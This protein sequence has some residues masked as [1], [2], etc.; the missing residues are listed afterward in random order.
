M[1]PQD[2][3]HDQL[4]K[5]KFVVHILDERY[6]ME[7]MVTDHITEKAIREELNQHP[8]ALQMGYSCVSLR[9]AK[10]ADDTDHLE[11][12]RAGETVEATFR[13]LDYASHRQ[14]QLTRLQRGDKLSV[15]A[16]R[17][18]VAM[19]PRFYPQAVTNIDEEFDDPPPLPPGVVPLGAQPATPAETAESI[20]DAS[21][22]RTRTPDPADRFDEAEQLPP[23]VTPK[24]K[25]TDDRT[26]AILTPPPSKR[27]SPTKRVQGP[28]FASQVVNNGSPAFL[29]EI[30]DF[31][32]DERSSSPVLDLNIHHPPLSS[33]PVAA[34]VPSEAEKQRAKKEQFQLEQVARWIKLHNENYS[35]RMIVVTGDQLIDHLGTTI[36]LSRSFPTE[37]T[38]EAY[39][40]DCI[41]FRTST[42]NADLHPVHRL[43]STLTPSLAGW[44]T[45]SQDGTE[46]RVIDISGQAV[47]AAHVHGNVCKMVLFDPDKRVERSPN[48]RKRIDLPVRT[49]FDIS[50]NPSTVSW[51]EEGTPA[52]Y[53]QV[54][55]SFETFWYMPDLRL[56]NEPEETKK[57]RERMLDEAA[58]KMRTLKPNALFIADANASKD[59]TAMPVIQSLIERVTDNYGLVFGVDPALEEKYT[60]HLDTK[61]LRTICDGI[62]DMAFGGYKQHKKKVYM[63]AYYYS[64][65]DA[66]MFF[67]RGKPRDDRVEVTGLPPFPADRFWPEK[68]FMAMPYYGQRDKRVHGIHERWTSTRATSFIVQ[69]LK[70]ATMGN[71]SMEVYTDRDGEAVAEV[72]RSEVNGSLILQRGSLPEK[73]TPIWLKRV[74]Y[75]WD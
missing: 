72:V 10:D 29:D 19:P 73:G 4:W 20:S 21:S 49:Y 69:G 57:R 42:G 33:D 39:L 62:A 34:Q 16:L 74:A 23:V 37:D 51:E 52:Y 27:R 68:E 8:R 17:E 61:D 63:N 44:L 36:P 6:G 1:A 70:K 48:R 64:H 24:R 40:E 26:Y 55:A 41:R 12:S 43:I 38:L 15:A 75:E 18:R 2:A 50:T 32:D 25:P 35:L 53:F 3:P 60:R 14:M 5:Q 13:R 67:A 66:G 11:Y 28:A 46:E 7:L 58:Q 47:D 71:P 59:T 30:M 45:L 54:S 9:Y 56:R 22:D 31:S 65:P